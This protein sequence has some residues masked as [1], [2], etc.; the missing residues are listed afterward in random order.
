MRKKKKAVRHLMGVDQCFHSNNIMEPHCQS[1]HKYMQGVNSASMY[2]VTFTYT[3]IH[4]HTYM[5]TYVCLH[6]TL[7]PSLH[8][9]W[10][11]NNQ[12]Y[13]EFFCIHQGGLDFPTKLVSFLP[14]PFP[15][16]KII[17]NQLLFSKFC[18]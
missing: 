5:H 10:S 11:D 8:A 12:D 15:G 1:I 7:T 3:Y 9:F 2:V 18:Y 4:R 14:S 13:G 16:N 6:Y 17:S